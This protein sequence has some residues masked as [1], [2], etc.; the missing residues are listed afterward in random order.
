MNWVIQTVAIYSERLGDSILMLADE[1]ICIRPAKI[2][3]YPYLNMNQVLSAAI[4]TEARYPGFG[5]LSEI[6]FPI[7]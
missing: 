5:F 6:K 3:G 4:V 1:A 2:N 7:S